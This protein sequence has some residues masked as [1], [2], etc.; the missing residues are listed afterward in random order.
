MIKDNVNWMDETDLWNL[1]QYAKHEIDYFQTSV[2]WSFKLI[3]EA[4][5]YTLTKK[6][7]T[8]DGCLALILKLAIYCDDVCIY[9]RKIMYLFC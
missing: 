7:K 1:S 3:E 6:L 5:I 4:I 9:V 8:K 2:Q